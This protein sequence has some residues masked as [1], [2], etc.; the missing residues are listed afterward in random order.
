MVQILFA[1][2][3]TYNFLEADPG[4]KSVRAVRVYNTVEM[5]VW[6]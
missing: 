2:G 6:R 3:I 1:A 5:F 4:N